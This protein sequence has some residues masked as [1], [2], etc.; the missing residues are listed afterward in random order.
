MGKP[1]SQP[2]ANLLCSLRISLAL[3]RADSPRQWSRGL[4]KSDQR[5][6]HEA[7][8]RQRRLIAGHDIPA[9]ASSCLSKGET[10]AKPTLRRGLWPIGHFCRTTNNRLRDSCAIGRPFAAPSRSHLSMTKRAGSVTHGNNAGN[11]AAS[12]KENIIYYNG[13]G[14]GGGGGIRTLG[15][16]TRTTVFE[17]APFDSSGGLHHRYERLAA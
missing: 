15:T 4:A 12:K 11:W 5:V 6:D 7:R 1:S 17:T 8:L 10:A 13:L 16:L 9:L 2:L 14:C 3:A